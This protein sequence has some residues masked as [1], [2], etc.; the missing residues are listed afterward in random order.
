MIASA[1]DS[2]INMPTGYAVL[3]DAALNKSTAFSREERDRYRL[4][5]LLPPRVCDQ[6]VQLAR[7][8]ENLRRKA[9][10]IERYIFLLTLQAR[11]E[12]LFYR[13]L[14][15]HIR[16]MMPLVYTPT[17]G[18]ACREFA[19]IF[20]QPRG[21]EYPQGAS[22]E[23]CALCRCGHSRNKPF[24]DGS[25]W[26][27]GFKDAEALTISAANRTEQE[28]ELHWVAVGQ[29]ADFEPGRVHGVLAGTR[30][31][32]LVH[33]ADGWCALDG[34]CPHQGGPLTEGT[35]SA[36]TVRCPWHGYDFR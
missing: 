28:T 4:R 1:V 20:R 8:L 31:V 26:Y 23:H 34:R 15:E 14:I 19:H 33:T 36:G 13:T 3:R 32:A 25:H 5:G 6:D 12:R 30:T 22:R 24:C 27:T 21:V 16:E 35:L 2:D 10:D 7:V 29:A 9:Y 18:Q 11:N 17:V